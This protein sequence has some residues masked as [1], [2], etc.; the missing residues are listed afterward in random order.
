M[1]LLSF[2]MVMND[3]S[4]H[5]IPLWIL[6]ETVGSAFG[7]YRCLRYFANSASM[8]AEIDVEILACGLSRCPRFLYL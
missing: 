4:K 6:L 3:E 1:G 5:D 7:C 2:S 8:P